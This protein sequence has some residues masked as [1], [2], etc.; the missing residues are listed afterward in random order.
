V[1]ISNDVAPLHT[2]HV[3]VCRCAYVCSGIG[4][5]TM[6]TGGTGPPAQKLGTIKLLIPQVLAVV[7]CK[8]WEYCM[9]CIICYGESD[10]HIPT[11]ELTMLAV[12]LVGQ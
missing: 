7:K 1:L 5:T 4:T 10:L 9:L 11:V 12:L 6:A 2:D 3:C 8:K